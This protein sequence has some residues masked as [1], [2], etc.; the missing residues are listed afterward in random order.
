MNDL[1]AVTVDVSK[2]TE[3]LGIIYTSLSHL[4]R[5]LLNMMN[6]EPHKIVKTK[7]VKEI[8]VK[9]LKHKATVPLVHKI[10]R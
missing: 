8:V 4:I 1:V 7:N 2:C 3:Q 5:D 9:L 6:V 10:V